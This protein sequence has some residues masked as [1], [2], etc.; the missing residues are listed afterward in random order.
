[1]WFAPAGAPAPSVGRSRVRVASLAVRAVLVGALGAGLALAA[2]LPATADDLD[3]TT[4]GV[5]FDG[6]ELD[7]RDRD[8]HVGYSIRSLEGWDYAWLTESLD[9]GRRG[10]VTFAS[11]ADEMPEGYCVAY[12]HVPGVGEWYESHR[13]PRCTE[14]AAAESAPPDEPSP[15]PAPSES[16]DPSPSPTAEPSAEAPSS[17]PSASPTPEPT[18]SATP[19]PSPSDEPSPSPSAVAT[20][21]AMGAEQFE[22]L[23]RSFSGELPA[24]DERNEAAEPAVN[25]GELWAVTGLGLA[26]AGLTAGGVVVWRLRARGD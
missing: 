12:V 23:G 24:V 1:M 15:T 19:T 3:V 20:G 21:A 4:D 14:P 5:A 18:P 11:A 10:Y 22:A 13:N 2:P 8:R 25:D 9:G 17:T 16:A 6:R 7:H 26:A